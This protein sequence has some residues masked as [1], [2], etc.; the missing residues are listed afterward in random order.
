MAS[1]PKK[2]SIRLN[3]FLFNVDTTKFETL[4]AETGK[5]V[6][7]YDLLA[8]LGM[9]GRIY[10]KERKE[11]RPRWADH[12]DMMHGSRLES[13][14]TLSASA[15][16]FIKIKKRV[17][18]FVFGYGRY[19]LDDGQVVLDF[20]IKTALNT[21][22]NTTLRSVDLYSMEQEPLQKRTQAVRSSNINTF[23]IDVSRDILKA[24]TGDARAGIEWETIHG[25]GFQY[26]F[27]AKIEAFNELKDIAEK[28]SG[29]YDLKIYKND[30]DWV[31][32]IQRVQNDSLRRTLDD[33]LIADLQKGIP[34]SLQ[35]TLPEVGEWDKIAGFS[36]TNA[37]TDIKSMIS[38]A[39][40]FAA[41]PA[42]GHTF[43]RL[44]SNRVFCYDVSENETFYSVY[45]CV[46][47]ELMHDK[48]F[49]ILFSSG[50]FCVDVDFLDRINLS[51]K[52]VKESALIFPDVETYAVPKISKKKKFSGISVEAEGAYNERVSKSCGFHLLDRKLIK[53]RTGASSIE[54]CDLLSDKGEFIH[55]KHKKGGSA[56]I[57]HLFAQ[58]RIA[59]ELM[60]SDKEFR[61]GARSKIPKSAKSLMPLDKFDPSTSEIVFLVLGDTSAQ[62]KNNLPFFSKI[63]L[64][65]TY[66]SLTQRNYEVS[67]AGASLAPALSAPISM[68]ATSVGTIPVAAP[69]P[70]S[71]ASRSLKTSTGAPRVKKP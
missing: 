61:K 49:Y 63:N 71:R 28:I 29:Y 40:Y 53:P 70:T 57:S 8:G 18:A 23:G 21:L 4:L 32:N 56:G 6:K 19:L 47:Y 2:L 65:L 17:I 41:N 37:K 44:K 34:A 62:V 33:L 27:T 68:G 51:L 50:W 54:L 14:T 66:Q 60:L 7:P 46:Y 12:L 36:Y 64:W 15:V 30:F 20:G 11:G 39:D 38:A 31:D 9:E 13:L 69:K 10:V 42:V 55:A 3:A 22:D 24:V 67:I 5:G 48:K 45:G 16:I 1:S 35:L 52:E 25:G 26:S 43:E 58:G 59:A